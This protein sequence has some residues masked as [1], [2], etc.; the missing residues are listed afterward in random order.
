MLE[1]LQ[2]LGILLLLAGIIGSAWLSF[3]NL[4]RR[5]AWLEQERA[6]LEREV[7]LR[8]E[9]YAQF[10][11]AVDTVTRDKAKAQLAIRQPLDNPPPGILPALREILSLPDV[12]ADPYYFPIG[13]RRRR[14]GA[15]SVTMFSAHPQNEHF[16]G[17]VAVTGETRYGKGNLVALIF[18]SLCMRLNPRQLHVFAVDPKRDFALWRGKAHNWREPVLGRDQA[19]IQAAMAALREERERRERLRERAGVLEHFQ[20]HESVRPPLLLVYLAE[21][22]VLQLGTDDLDE[23]LASEMSTCLASGIIYVI[24][25]QNNSR[26]ATRWRTHF[27]TFLAAFQSSEASV[28]PN[29]GMRPDEIERLG[30]IS[31]HKLPGKGYFTYRSG[32][33]VGSVRAPLISLEARQEA[34]AS[35]PT[36]QQPHSI[37]P[38]APAA[39]GAVPGAIET[40]RPKVVVTAEERARIIA[41]APRHSSR[42]DL[43]AA[44]FNGRRTGEPAQKVKLVCDELG[45]L[46]PNVDRE[47]QPAEAA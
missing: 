26:R 12:A 25:A 31:P 22:D 17:N 16:C 33:D 3:Q 37:T 35:L 9:R 32:R 46:I 20:L 14:D 15:A 40:R 8:D 39:V 18:L 45:I 1:G 7:A 4:R 23:W 6:R 2:G 13:W 11:H 38:L 42:G 27:S 24:D 28:E 21:L 10:Y 41:E 29:V 34:L 30:G 43:T 19:M 5:T 47:P 36:A 44:V